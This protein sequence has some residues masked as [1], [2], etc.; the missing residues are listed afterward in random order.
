MSELTLELTYDDQPSVRM[1]HTSVSGSTVLLN[2]RF[3]LE[4]LTLVPDLN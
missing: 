3:L 2:H 4:L 1:M